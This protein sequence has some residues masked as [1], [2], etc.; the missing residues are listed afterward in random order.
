MDD[1]RDVALRRAAVARGDAP[2]LERTGAS[3]GER[4]GVRARRV[5]P[6]E[7]DEVGVG[8]LLLDVRE[9]DG[10]AVDVV[11]RLALELEAELLELALQA[12]AAGQLAHRQAGA[13]EAHRLRGH[14]LVGERVLEHAV[15]VDARLV[16]EGVAAD[17]GLVGLDGEAR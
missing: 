11:E 14:D 12:A 7:R 3:A 15:L 1:E 2:A 8:D 9:R 10:R 4:L 16:R 6:D 5:L 13:R 17:D